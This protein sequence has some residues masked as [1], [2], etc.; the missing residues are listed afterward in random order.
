VFPILIS[1]S[2]GVLA[3]EAIVKWGREEELK[4]KTLIA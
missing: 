2:L 3:A 4:K 1:L